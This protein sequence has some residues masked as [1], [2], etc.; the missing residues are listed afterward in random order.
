MPRAA[1]AVTPAIQLHLERIPACY[2]MLTNGV[3][4]RLMAGFDKAAA[5][6]SGTVS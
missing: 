6:L 5:E 4:R 3:L 2:E 1:V